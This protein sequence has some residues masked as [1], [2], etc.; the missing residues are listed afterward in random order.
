LFS[1]LRKSDVEFA[2]YELSSRALQLLKPFICA[3]RSTMHMISSASSTCCIELLS[4]LMPSLFEI[5]QLRIIIVEV[6][7]DTAKLILKAFEQ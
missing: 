4:V 6:L 5:D 1:L 7:N 3:L 2:E